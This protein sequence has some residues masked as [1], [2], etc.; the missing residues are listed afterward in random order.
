M[1]LTQNTV[2]SVET[3]TKI[4]EMLDEMAHE[5]WLFQEYDWLFQEHA[6]LEDILLNVF[7]DVIRFWTHTIKFLSRHPAGE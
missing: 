5:L 2:K 1:F 3:L 4:V 7:V 6:G